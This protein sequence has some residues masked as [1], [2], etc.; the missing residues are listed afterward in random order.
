MG[1]RGDGPSG[2]V[3]AM[4]AGSGPIRYRAGKALRI[5]RGAEISRVFEIG[6][7]LADRRLTL[8]VAPAPTPVSRMAAAVSKR[9]GNA[10]RRNRLKRLCREA[11][12]LVRPELPAGLD[13][14]MLPRPGREATLA[15]LMESLIALAGRIDGVVHDD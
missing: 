10:V 7:R 13:Y 14:V 11:F 3:W 6:Q 9:H 15:E 1:Y 12:R 4:T 8:L 2:T 5:K